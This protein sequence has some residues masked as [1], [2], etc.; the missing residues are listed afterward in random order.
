MGLNPAL[1]EQAG[2]NTGLESLNVIK[3][4]L[5]AGA[6]QSE[7]GLL[8]YSGINITDDIL[9]LAQRN[10]LPSQ[11]EV[12]G[13]LNS[14]EAEWAAQLL[15][16][17][18]NSSQIESLAGY[19]IRPSSYVRFGITSSEAAQTV[20]EACSVIENGLRDIWIYKN[21]YKNGRRTK[22]LLGIQWLCK[23]P[24]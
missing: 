21:C 23:S 19:G 5:Q 11:Y 24:I 6:P 8:I 15:R 7:I 14:T 3:G 13:I 18:I 4:L 2:K 12:Y 22:Q 20:A 9:Y 16:R 1:I 10:I 17:G